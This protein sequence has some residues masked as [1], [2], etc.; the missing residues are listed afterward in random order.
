MP[1]GFFD[2][3]RTLS[4][5]SPTHLYLL[6]HPALRPWIAHYTL[7]PGTGVLPGNLPPLTLVPDASGCLAFTL[8]SGALDG[9]LF[10]PSTR[11]VAVENDLGLCP[12]RFFVEFRPG[13][14]R[15]F[16]DLPQAELADQSLP[17]GEVER[18]LDELVRRCWDSAPDLDEFVAAVERGLLAR[19]RETSPLPRLLA[20]WGREA[21]QPLARLAGETGYS[22]RH[23]AR[24]FHEEAGMTPKDFLRVARVNAAAARLRAGAPSLTALAQELGY[25]DQAHF[26]HD[27]RTVCG[28]TPG[29]YRAALTDFYNE[30][31]KF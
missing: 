9:L 1:S 23:L 7:C 21:A 24:L 31:L 25:F 3:Y 11:A 16:T 18:D 10:G 14:L 15:A 30:P 26:I 17:L 6:P 2:R 12:L 13:G 22:R 4:G 27:F 8:T 28:V 29:G 5:R 19:R 20:L